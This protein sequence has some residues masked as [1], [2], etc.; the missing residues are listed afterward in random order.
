MNGDTG[1]I[2]V[3]YSGTINVNLQFYL[4]LHI[5]LICGLSAEKNFSD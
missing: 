1:Q 2:S 4:F 5:Y 3:R